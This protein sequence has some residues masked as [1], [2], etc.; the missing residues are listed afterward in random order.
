[1]LV[2]LQVELP[3]MDITFVEKLM[4]GDLVYSFLKSTNS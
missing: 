4:H 1:M 2:A 3:E